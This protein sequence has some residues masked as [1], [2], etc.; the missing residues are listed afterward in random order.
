MAGVGGTGEERNRPAI[1][2][3][4]VRMQGLAPPDLWAVEGYREDSRVAIS[5]SLLG[6]VAVE[7]KVHGSGVGLGR[8]QSRAH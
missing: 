4:G 1:T 5:K 6:Q 8:D 3:Y 7:G 2:S